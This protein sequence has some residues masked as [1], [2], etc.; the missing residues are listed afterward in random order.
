MGAILLLLL[1]PQ[2]FWHGQVGGGGDGFEMIQAHYLYCV[3]DFYYYISSTSD[4]QAL[5]PG[6]CG[7][8][9]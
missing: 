7:P 4:H 9:P 3:L 8:L 5:H 1:D 6:D 2:H